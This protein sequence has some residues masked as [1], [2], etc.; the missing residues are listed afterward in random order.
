M[1]EVRNNG[2]PLLERAPKA[3]ITQS[4]IELAAAIDGGL[5]VTQTG[6]K[7]GISRFLGFLNKG[8]NAKSESGRGD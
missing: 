7:A 8:S 5:S 4:I 6:D 2:V 1:S 3:A